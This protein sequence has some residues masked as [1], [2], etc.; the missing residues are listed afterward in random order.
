M[1]SIVHLFA[2]DFFFALHICC[3]WPFMT[4]LNLV[5]K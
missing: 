3:T 4:P 5:L 1:E 2:Y